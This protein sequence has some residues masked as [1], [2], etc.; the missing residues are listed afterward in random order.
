VSQKISQSNE[1]MS[2]SGLKTRAVTRIWNQNQ[3]K[4]KHLLFSMVGGNT[5]FSG[6]QFISKT[7]FY[8]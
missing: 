7:A 5:N 1:A 6:R 4:K 3:F 2:R 8:Q